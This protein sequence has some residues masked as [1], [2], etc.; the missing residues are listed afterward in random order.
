MDRKEFFRNSGRWVFLGALAFVAG[1]F[2]ANRQI[3]GQPECPVSKRCIN[4]SRF[5]GCPLP[6]ANKLKGNGR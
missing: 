5:S 2:L 3:S 1:Y 4:C 6:Q